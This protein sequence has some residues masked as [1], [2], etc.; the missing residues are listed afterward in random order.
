MD[1][2]YSLPPPDERSRVAGRLQAIFSALVS[3]S[4]PPLA[5]WRLTRRDQHQHFGSLNDQM[6]ADIGLQRSMMRAA[7]YGIMP[8]NQVMSIGS[9]RDPAN[10]R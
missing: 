2:Q 7:E 5:K 1:R 3:A 4:W 10:D 6:L 9:D 8:T